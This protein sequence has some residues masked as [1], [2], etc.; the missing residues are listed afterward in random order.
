MVRADADGGAGTADGAD[1]EADYE[2]C[3]SVELGAV[4]TEECIGTVGREQQERA[5]RRS[6]VEKTSKIKSEYFF[7]KADFS[8]LCNR[9]PV[10]RE[11]WKYTL[12]ELEVYSDG[13]GSILLRKWGY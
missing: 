9:K 12:T 6:A 8:L 7:C 1:G 11:I 5:Q 3:V 4:G 10:L 13:A 2:L